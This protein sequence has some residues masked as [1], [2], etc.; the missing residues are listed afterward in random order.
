M[1][2]TV[3][4]SCKLLEKNYTYKECEDEVSQVLGPDEIHVIN[5]KVSFDKNILVIVE[6]ILSARNA[7]KK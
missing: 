5:R 7:R 1:S 2:V 6:K 3:S 4:F